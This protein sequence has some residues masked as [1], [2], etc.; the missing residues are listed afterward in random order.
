MKDFN[1]KIKMIIFH[2]YMIIYVEDLNKS[3]DKSLQ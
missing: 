3:I 1:G 2:R